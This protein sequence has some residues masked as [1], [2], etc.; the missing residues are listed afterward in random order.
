MNDKFKIEI[1][2]QPSVEDVRVIEDGLGASVPDGVPP[3][4]YQ[5]LVVLLKAS[6]GK[7]IGGLEGST[8]WDWL[9]IRLLW[10]SNDMR[11]YGCG[12]KLVEAAEKCAVNR[13]CH[14]AVVDTF[15]F[16]AREFYEALGYEMFGSL[17]DFPTGHK[18]IYLKKSLSRRIGQTIG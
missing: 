7:I 11:G 17:D 14:G 4:D 8:Y 12:R 2:D 10:V 18:R 15:S 3:R 1:M 13:G 16:Q 6:D 9:N 5:P